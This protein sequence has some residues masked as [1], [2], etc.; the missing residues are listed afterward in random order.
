[1]RQGFE[2]A[3]YWSSKDRLADRDTVNDVLLKTQKEHPEVP[4]FSPLVHST[5]AIGAGVEAT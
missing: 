3:A 5:S 1:M 4:E 2:R